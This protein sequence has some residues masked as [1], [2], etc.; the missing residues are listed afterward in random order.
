MTGEL[1]TVGDIRE[2]FQKCH[3]LATPVAVR[4]RRQALVNENFVHGL[5][6][7][8]AVTKNGQAETKADAW[9][10][11]EGVPRLYVNECQGLMTTWS[12]LLNRDRKSALAVPASEEPEDLYAA[13]V[14]NK[15]IAFF[16]AEE[17]TAQKV[18]GAVQDAFVAGTAGLKIMYDRDEDRITWSPLTVHNFLIDP[19]VGDW[20]D[21]KWVIFQ[22]YYS[23]DEVA[24]LWERNSLEGTP[25]RDIEYR[26]ANGDVLRGI[27]GYEFWHLPTRAFPQGFYACIVDDQVVER[28]AYPYARNTDGK[29]E[30]LLPLSLMRVRKIRESVYGATPMSD[31]V[32]LQRS[33]NE[34]V[35][36]LMKLVR[37]TTNVHLILPQEIPEFDA[38]QSV[39]IRFPAKMSD[40]AARIGYTQPPQ[41]SPVLF[42]LRDY[43]R[44]AMNEV[45]GL[46]DVTTGTENRSLSGKAIENIIAL[47]AQ[48]NADASKGLEDML[49]HAFRVTA[50]LV[51]IFY[52]TERKE[53]I[54][55][56]GAAEVFAFDGAD[57]QGVD[58]RLEPSSEVDQLS[59]V[60]S[61]AAAE[62]LSAGLGTP[63]D[64][65][66]AQR[67]PQ[68]LFSRKLAEQLVAEFLAGHEI[69]VSPDD[70]DADV[71]TD[72]IRRHKALALSQRR[73]EDWRALH[74]FETWVQDELVAAQG[75]ARPT[76]TNDQPANQQT[77]AAPSVGEVQKP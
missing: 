6:W 44:G 75:E 70:V 40:A 56:A 47:D 54:M 29:P 48:K 35:S 46:N 23:E 31:V 73:R 50:A 17:E 24:D 42:E 77:P 14:F 43:F 57:I 11:D 65:Q 61:G 68:Y 13:E 28:M 71:L 15:F 36:R 27:L 34:M 5:Q 30:Y 58:I 8:V 2:R 41:V 49:L 10:D 74:R 55:S 26:T 22:H 9:F 12:A 39:E 53:R 1:P 64:L 3:D 62:K 59:T 4:A 7:G 60:K 63:L 21:A 76:P 51:Q 20:R 52:T 19:G 72:V 45:A 25:P 18:H 67:T 16:C 32:P 69:D 38:K 66:K 37:Q 33:M